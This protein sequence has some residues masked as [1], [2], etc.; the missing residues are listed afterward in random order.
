VKLFRPSARE[1]YS[2]RPRN[3]ASMLR[4]D[5]PVL[6]ILIFIAMSAIFFLFLKVTERKIPVGLVPDSTN[7]RM[8][9]DSAHA[10]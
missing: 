8:I 7:A 10:K 6:R 4:S 9:E 3:I 5:S 2:D 1:K